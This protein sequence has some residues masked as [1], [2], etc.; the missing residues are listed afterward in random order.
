M[1]TPKFAPRA[2]KTGTKPSDLALKMIDVQE[3]ARM[4]KMEIDSQTKKDVNRT[5][6]EIAAGRLC[7][8]GFLVSIWFEGLDE[9]DSLFKGTRSFRFKVGKRKLFYSRPAPTA[10]WF[11]IKE[12]CIAFKLMY[13]SHFREW[14]N[15]VPYD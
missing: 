14:A 15:S 13:E 10:M 12:N 6:S 7:E 11:P 8:H 2:L 9:H 1:I 4:S 3:L 5:M